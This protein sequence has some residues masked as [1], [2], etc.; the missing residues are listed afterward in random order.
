MDCILVAGVTGWCEV[1]EE[2]KKQSRM[3]TGCLLQR[4]I[5]ILVVLLHRC[6]SA[7]HC[8]TKYSGPYNTRDAGEAGENF[9]TKPR[10]LE[11]A[12]KTLE[13]NGAQQLTGPAIHTCC[14]FCSTVFFQSPSL[15]RHGNVK[16][17]EG[18]A[19]NQLFTQSELVL[20]S[21][22]FNLFVSKPKTH[23]ATPT[24]PPHS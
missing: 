7:S 4:V 24:H 11:T 22:L 10:G 3:H 2:T 17:K 16:E 9:C 21:L 19:T 6:L 12:M 15:N 5:Q 14:L 1:G 8:G 23:V 20:Y 18:W 13:H